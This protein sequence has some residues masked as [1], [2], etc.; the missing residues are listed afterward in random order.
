M[1]DNQTKTFI[2][3]LISDK[4][5]QFFIKE[6]MIGC[7]IGDQNKPNT[8]G[9]L[10]LVY[11]YPPTLNW[12]QYEKSLRKIPSFLHRYEY[13][14]PNE[15]VIVIYEFSLEQNTEDLEKIIEGKYSEIS[16]EGKLRISKFWEVYSGTTLPTKILEKHKDL[17]YHWMKRQEDPRDHCINDEMWYLPNMEDEIFSLEKYI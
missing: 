9:N 15:K 5:P 4:S 10:L 16:P 17:K 14:K 3:P 12:I 2:L 1:K 13:V 6:E 7:F 8:D 11:N